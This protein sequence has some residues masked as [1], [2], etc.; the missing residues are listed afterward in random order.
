MREVVFRIY[1]DLNGIKWKR[2]TEREI[3][4]RLNS[5]HSVKDLVESLGIPHGEVGMLLV[6]DEIEDFDRKLYG[7]ERVSVYPVFRSIDVRSVS[8]TLMEYPQEA[9]FILDVHLGKLAKYLRMLGF[10]TLYEVDG[11]DFWLAD[12]SEAEG[13]IL[14]SLDRELLMRKNVPYPY[15]VRSRDPLEQLRETVEKFCLIERMEPLSRCMVCNGK[16]KQMEKEKI[17]GILPEGVAETNEIF[18]RCDSCGKIYWSGTHTEGMKNIIDNLLKT[19]VKDGR[20]MED[21]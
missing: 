10:D 17:L 5:T 18:K 21:E 13:R 16:L 14:L 8:K 1:G 11:E 3:S 4:L 15:L 19:S 6:D 20:C 2:F 7:G 12:K 9:K